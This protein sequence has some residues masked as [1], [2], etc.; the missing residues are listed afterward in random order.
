M[1]EGDT[2]EVARRKVVK[3]DRIKEGVV[4]G[5]KKKIVKRR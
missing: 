1:K 4:Y 3:V 2:K 5:K